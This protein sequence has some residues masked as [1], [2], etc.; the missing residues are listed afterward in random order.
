MN[1]K[2]IIFIIIPLIVFIN[3][4]NCQ[5]DEICDEIFLPFMT[6]KDRRS[7]HELR[8]RAL[9][10]FGAY[11]RRGHKHAGL[12]IKADFN[13]TVYAVG[14]GKLVKIYDKFP[15]QTVLV[16]H[17]LPSGEIFYSSYIHIEDIGVQVG[18][19]VDQ[20]TPVG[21]VFSKTE[22]KKTNFP[23]NHLHFEIRKTL[24]NYKRISIRCY[25][26]EDLNKNFHDPMKFFAQHL[27][28]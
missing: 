14:K 2:T 5:A 12:D 20:N 18:D 1:L 16:E 26:M 8:K 11:R 6:F 23:H 19:F 9:D 21:R 7:F 28:K 15:Y 4:L 27:D 13:E 3:P 10:G 22:Y 24:E 17:K 25:T